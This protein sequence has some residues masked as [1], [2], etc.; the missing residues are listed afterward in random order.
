MKGNSAIRLTTS[1]VS[2]NEIDG[3]VRYTNHRSGAVTFFQCSGA[4]LRNIHAKCVGPSAVLQGEWPTAAPGW[5]GVAHLRAGL[6]MLEIG[7][8]MGNP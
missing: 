8:I 2:Q 3:L 1:A 4:C 7:R 5:R 6:P